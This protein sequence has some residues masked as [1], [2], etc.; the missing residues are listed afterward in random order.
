MNLLQI[1]CV[2]T[3]AHKKFSLQPQKKKKR[4]FF[5]IFWIRTLY[6]KRFRSSDLFV[7]STLPQRMN[8]VKGKILVQDNC[9]NFRI[10]SSWNYPPKRICYWQATTW[11]WHDLLFLAHW[12]L[13]DLEWIWYK[14]IVWILK[15][16]QMNPNRSK[17]ASLLQYYSA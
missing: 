17:V 8:F 5:W 12:N 10:Q 16:D 9:Q 13:L 15:C 11:K 2:M 6:V 4:P 14:I 1:S 3:W 7:F